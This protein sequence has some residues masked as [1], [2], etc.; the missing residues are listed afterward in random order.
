M[1]SKIFE[2]IQKKMGGSIDLVTKNNYYI[3]TIII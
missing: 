3:I 1:H 2:K